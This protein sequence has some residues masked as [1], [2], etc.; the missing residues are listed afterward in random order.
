VVNEWA[1][2]V[3]AET[4]VLDELKLAAQHSY[5]KLNARITTGVAQS[6]AEARGQ[7]DARA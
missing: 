7:A 6:E 4:F 2:A 3:L 5:F 1:K